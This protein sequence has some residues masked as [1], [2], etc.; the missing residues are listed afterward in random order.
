[1]VSNNCF[2][3][4]HVRQGRLSLTNGTKIEGSFG[5]SWHEKIEIVKATLEDSDRVKEDTDSAHSVIAEL[6]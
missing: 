4:L 1:M 2:S 5:G 3:F 6:Q